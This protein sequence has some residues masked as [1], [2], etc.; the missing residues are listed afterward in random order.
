MIDQNI[1]AQQAEIAKLDD[2]YL[3][4]QLKLPANE[5]TVSQFLAAIEMSKRS[6]MRKRAGALID[7]Y[8]DKGTVVDETLAQMQGAQ[9]PAPMP[10][11]GFAGGGTVLPF[12]WRNWETPTTEDYPQGFD[13]EQG[14]FTGIVKYIGRLPQRVDWEGAFRSDPGF[15]YPDAAGPTFVS[16]APSGPAEYGSFGQ[17]PAGLAAAVGGPAFGPVQPAYG[18]PM[19]YGS[20]NYA[21]PANMTP[22]LADEAKSRFD[23]IMAMRGPAPAGPVEQGVADAANIMDAIRPPG[24]GEVSLPSAPSGG[25]KSAPDYMAKYEEMLG[26]IKTSTPTEIPKPRQLDE[27]DTKRADRLNRA[28][29]LGQMAKAIATSP[30]FIAGIGE[31][32]GD[33]TTTMAAARSKLQ[34]EQMDRAKIQ[35]QYD[36]ANTELQARERLSD[37]QSANAI[38]LARIEAVRDQAMADQSAANQQALAR[39]EMQGRMAMAQYQTAAEAEMR[40]FDAEARRLEAEATRAAAYGM[41]GREEQFQL[42]RDELEQR[43]TTARAQ[44]T[45]QMALLG[46]A[47]DGGIEMA[48]AANAE[49]AGPYIHQMLRTLMGASGRGGLPTV[50]K[51]E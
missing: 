48:K 4:E 27:I 9:A 34:Q 18:G 49:D 12:R 46:K 3:A 16:P 7:T 51:V 14:K 45:S 13:P 28:M 31:G 30:N 35:A 6:Q 32:V 43:A 37:K 40:R 2:N 8:K 44:A 47:I 33:A 23:R 10:Q 38:N 17:A 20:G 39:Y 26:A 41:R 36:I 5:A 50:K 15:Q 25:S 1:S 29:A 21:A 42:M 22:L 11:Q 19:E 24:G